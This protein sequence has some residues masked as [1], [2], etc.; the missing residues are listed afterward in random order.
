M[1]VDR[2]VRCPVHGFI[3]LHADHADIVASKPFQRLRGIRQLAFAS[4]LYPGALHTR[5]DHSLGVYHVAQLLCERL[6]LT[7]SDSKLV[8]LAALL[9]DLGHGPFSHVSENVL[10]RYADRDKLAKRIKAKEK[11]H[12][13]VTADIVL[14]DG[15]LAKCITEKDRGRIVR[16]LGASYGEPLMRDIITGP[17]DAD[18]QD[19]LLRDSL[20][21]GV[22]YGVFDIHQ[23]HRSLCVGR[24]GQEKSLMVEP[25][26]V[27][28]LEQFIL[29][30]Y[31][32]TT[33]VYAH[34]VRLITDHMLTRALVLGIEVDG[35]DEL[36][37][38]YTY[39]GSPDFARRYAEWDDASLLL[40][41]TSDRFPGKYCH[42]LLTR[43]RRRQLLKQ[44]FARPVTKEVFEDGHLRDGLVRL[45]QRE[46]TVR[47]Q[48]QQDEL[49]A[50]IEEALAEAIGKQAGS[51][52]DPRLV[53]L[54][55]YTTKSVR[56]QTREDEKAI[57]VSKRPRPVPFEEESSLFRSI[58]ERM[59][60]TVVEVYAPVTYE[61]EAQQRHLTESLEEA[62]KRVLQEHLREGDEA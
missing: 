25:P 54:N 9:H 37:E 23:L 22:Q 24:Q 62:T 7:P 50:G 57:L 51:A 17:L 26:G 16:L 58:D 36:R 15:E 18:K 13:L 39:D 45:T 11:I 5:F 53:V 27:H 49:R 47:A 20:F 2:Q 35:V 19:Y 44:V 6:R 32:L 21:C 14:N 46:E 41:Y 1:S 29:A 3:H 8:Q 42:D 40:A 56:A 4:L 55:V 60:E 33:Q 38:L 52:V 28:A 61:T 34:R 48:R 59:Q 31:F 30:K 43:L 12:E 10:E